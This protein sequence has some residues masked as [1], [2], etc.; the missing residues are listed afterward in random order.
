MIRHLLPMAMASAL[1]AGCGDKQLP[2]AE[3]FPEKSPEPAQTEPV[4][5]VEQEPDQS[6][7]AV[8]WES[9]LVEEESIYGLPLV[10]N[11]DNLPEIPA[12][13]LGPSPPIVEQE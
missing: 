1:L 11:I 3:R 9:L 10:I 6:P 4:A 2:P 5:S 13:L 8:E 7:A 12:R